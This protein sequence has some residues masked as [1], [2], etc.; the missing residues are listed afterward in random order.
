M[1]AEAFGIGIPLTLNVFIIKYNKQKRIYNVHKYLQKHL[2]MWSY[3]LMGIEF[4]IGVMK[5][6]ETMMLV[7]QHCEYN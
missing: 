4:L 6:F 2:C 5:H 7:I 1:A 3:Y